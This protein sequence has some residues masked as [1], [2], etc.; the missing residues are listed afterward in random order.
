MID[1]VPLD[2]SEK[3][4]RRRDEKRGSSR[5]QFYGVRMFLTSRD[6]LDAPIPMSNFATWVELLSE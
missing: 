5:V 6:N 4:P 2:G 3:E 1:I